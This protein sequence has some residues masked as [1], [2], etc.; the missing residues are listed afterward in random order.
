MNPSGWLSSTAVLVQSSGEAGTAAR[1]DA[2]PHHPL[3]SEDSVLLQRELGTIEELRDL[4]PDS[5][6]TLLF[7]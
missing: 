2:W 6:C 3:A 1:T 5:K 4:E 7:I